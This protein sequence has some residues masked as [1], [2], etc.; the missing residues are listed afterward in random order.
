VSLRKPKGEQWELPNKETLPA[1]VKAAHQLMQRGRRFGCQCGMVY[2]TVR[3]LQ[4]S[5]LTHGL[6]IRAII[7]RLEEPTKDHY[8]EE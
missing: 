2:S 6:H 5:R 3:T 7:E 4:E 8:A 1:Q